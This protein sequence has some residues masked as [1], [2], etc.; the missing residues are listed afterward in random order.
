AASLDDA[1]ASLLDAEGYRA[2]IDE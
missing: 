2:T 1:L